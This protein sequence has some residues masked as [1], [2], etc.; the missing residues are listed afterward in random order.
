MKNCPKC[1]APLED[2]AVFCPVCG[3]K[4]VVEEVKDDVIAS[5]KREAPEEAAQAVSA[6]LK[7][8]KNLK[9]ILIP[10]VAV[11]AVVIAIILI[12]P[13]FG[14][15]KAPKGVMYAADE[16]IFF[17]DY[18]K[19][20]GV[21]VTE[22]LNDTKGFASSQLSGA[23]NL[24]LLSE[25]GDIL[26]YPDRID[27]DSWSLYWKNFNKLDKEGTKIDSKLDSDSYY[28]SEDGR[29]VAYTKEGKLIQYDIKKDD[30]QKIASDVTWFCMSVDG[31]EFIYQNNE[32]DLY[33]YEKEKEKMAKSQQA[34][35]TV[36][37]EIEN[38]KKMM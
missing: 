37:A 36:L 2:D 3:E 30:K 16:E 8:S 26:F 5:E 17:T 20:G 15:D 7:K 28:I 9:K 38:L 22:K 21:Q 6:P 1:Q 31:K 23:L 33:R 14:G 29:Y 19:K 4:L 25:K 34:L 10:V 35:D 12:A 18:G 24:T 13:L 27:E 11:I 32:G